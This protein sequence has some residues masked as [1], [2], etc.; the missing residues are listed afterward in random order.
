M[1]KLYGFGPAFGISEA[2]PFVLKVDLFLRMSN[3]E[4]KVIARTAN[5]QKAPKGKLPFIKDD[6]TVIADSQFIIRYLEKKYNV[7]LDKNLSAEQKSISRLLGKSLDESLYW[8]LVYSRWAKD[9]TWAEVKAAFFDAMPFP[10][11]IIV[12]IIARKSTIKALNNQGF[13]RH[14]NEELL[15][16]ANESFQ[17]LSIF[18]DDKPYFFGEYPSSFDVTV[19]TLLTQFIDVTLDNDFNRAARQYPNLVDYCSRMI[20]EY[21]PQNN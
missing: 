9:D 4:F 21:Y 5:L 2:S 17:A 1:I 16:I 18:L 20:S 15:E 8:C 6:D 3:I 19:F 12:P 11:R 7:D 13:G 14:S 10:L